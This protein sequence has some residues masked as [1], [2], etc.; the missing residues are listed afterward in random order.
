MR[1]DFEILI[2]GEMALLRRIVE[3]EISNLPVT[4]DLR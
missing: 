3:S 2:F 4:P 1:A